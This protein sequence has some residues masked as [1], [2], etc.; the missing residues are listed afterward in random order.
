MSHLKITAL[1]NATT[2]LDPKLVQSTSSQPTLHAPMTVKYA[3][4]HY[5][6]TQSRFIITMQ[7]T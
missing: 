1:I 4:P 3:I 6:L 5:T 2:R 7:E